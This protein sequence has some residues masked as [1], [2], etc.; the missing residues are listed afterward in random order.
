VGSPNGSYPVV[1]SCLCDFQLEVA[2][3]RGGEEAVRLLPAHRPAVVVCELP[4]DD[5]PPAALVSRLRRADPTVAVILIAGGSRGPDLAQVVQ[6][7]ADEYVPRPVDRGKLMVA[8]ARALNRQRTAV[9]AARNRL[10]DVLDG[11][12]R[13]VAGAV[14]ALRR[15]LEAKDFLSD[16]HAETVGD[17][18][19]RIARQHGLS[20]DEVRHARLAGLLHDLGKVAVDQLILERPRSLTT[21]EWRE[22][23][24]HPVRG[25]EILATIEPL[26]NV[27]RYVLHH[28]ERPDGGGYPDGLRG[29]DIPLASRI[30]A[31][32]DAYDA[33]VR[34]RPYRATDGPTYA[35]R[36]FRRHAGTQWDP[37]VVESLFACVPELRL[38]G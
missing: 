11:S 3:A 21:A 33:M 26:G 12:D 28:H 31:V 7:G 5:L 14:E 18:A 17:L 30:I 10:L 32:A 1:M 9:Q 4:L 6:V 25:A 22:V 2:E 23:R 13:V 29:Q 19:G 16:G 27:A 34:P 35:S 36:E 37:G 15:C 20:D 24:I 8:T 38:A